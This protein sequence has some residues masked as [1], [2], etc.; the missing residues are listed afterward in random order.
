VPKP[1]GRLWHAF[2]R[3]RATER[4]ALPVKDVAAAGGWKD[5]TTLINCYQQPDEDTLRSMVEFTPPAPAL[6]SRKARAGGH[7]HYSHTPHIGEARQRLSRCRASLPLLGSNQDS[8][9]PES[10]GR[11]RHFGQLVGNRPLSEH[12]CP[13]PG[14][15]LPAHARR[16]YGKTTAPSCSSPPRRT[17]QITLEST[18]LPPP[19]A[20]EN[21][22][23]LPTTCPHRPSYV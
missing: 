4:N 6:R 14:R 23:H 2:R 1:D 9:D 16:N 8:P 11:G 10:P 21:R 12:R 18:R 3:L 17:C 5:V 13:L 20:I 22:Y 19:S 7:K 15:S